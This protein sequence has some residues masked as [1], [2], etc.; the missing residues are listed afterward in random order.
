MGGVK[1]RVSGTEGAA[2]Y[3][4]V[5]NNVHQSGPEVFACSFFKDPCDSGRSS[6]LRILQISAVMSSTALADSTDKDQT[7]A[8]VPRR[9]KNMPPDLL[10]SLNKIVKHIDS[11][12]N[13]FKEKETR[14]T[15]IKGEF[16][17]IG[18]E[19]KNKLE[20]ADAVKTGGLI[21]G[22]ISLGV[23][24]LGLAGAFFTGGASLLASAAAVGGGTAGV[25]GGV[26]AL[27]GV[28]AGYLIESG[29]AENIKAEGNL[30]IY[31][32]TP[33]AKILAE[34]E[35]LC[36]K[37]EKD[38]ANTQSEDVNEYRGLIRRVKSSSATSQG[39]AGAVRN[40]MTEILELI[41]K[42]FQK[43]LSD[44]EER[45]LSTL[46]IDSGGQCENIISTFRDLKKE[47]LKFKEDVEELN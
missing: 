44:K 6:N 24:A 33:M 8:S 39:K 9:K 7:M 14:M 34:I 17:R 25:V 23:F 4:C 29:G 13:M 12:V 2:L 41:S 40:F 15:E 38:S 46:V 18:K 47:L 43:T 28:I 1:S 31:I 30:F 21:G 11:Y 5:E 42:A 10:E 45:D 35:K 16:H 22:G 19:V 20:I 36:E 26:I 32:I 3:N 37:W 27:G